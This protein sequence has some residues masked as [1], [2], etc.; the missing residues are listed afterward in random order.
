[1]NAIIGLQYVPRIAVSA[2]ARIFSIIDVMTQPLDDEDF[3]R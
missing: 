2:V 3:P 1:M